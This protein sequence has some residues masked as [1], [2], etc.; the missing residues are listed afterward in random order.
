M[1][2]DLL[3]MKCSAGNQRIVG[4]PGALMSRDRRQDSGLMN[5][6]DHAPG[7]TTRRT[8]EQSELDWLRPF[9][10]S[11]HL[12][13]ADILFSKGDPADSMA[14]IL[15][16]RFRIGALHFDLGP[17]QVAGEMEMLSSA[18]R[19][20]QTVTCLEPGE[21]LVIDP[22]GIRRLYTQN[23]SF[24]FLLFELTTQRL[25]DNIVMLEK[26]LIARSA[27]AGS[28]KHIRR[29]PDQ[30]GKQVSDIQADV[31]E[32]ALEVERTISDL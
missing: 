18:R 19:R 32:R 24:G 1:R 31:L 12:K 9:A 15:S 10:V 23:P 4:P 5:G 13:G 22:A 21:V 29:G 28:E 11:R 30:T 16:G 14:F 6:P 20:T 26:R 17:G 8:G 25:F 27:S 3:S 7:E 2:G